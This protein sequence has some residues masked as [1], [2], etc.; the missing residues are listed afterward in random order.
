MTDIILGYTFLTGLT[1]MSAYSIYRDYNP[2]LETLKSRKRKREE[3][4]ANVQ[5]GEWCLER[6]RKQINWEERW[7]KENKILEY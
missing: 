6:E 5:I 4:S 1:L 7:L 3:P 2:T